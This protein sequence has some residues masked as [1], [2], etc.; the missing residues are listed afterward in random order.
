MTV[1]ERA[2]GRQPGD[3]PDNDYFAPEPIVGIGRRQA[4]RL[5]PMSCAGCGARPARRQA[6]L[7]GRPASLCARCAA[8]LARRKGQTA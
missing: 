8:G 7:R 1:R 6:I 3:A 5:V 4:G 2:P